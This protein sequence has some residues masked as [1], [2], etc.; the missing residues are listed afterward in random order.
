MTV[1]SNATLGGSCVVG[2]TAVLNGATI[3]PGDSPG[4]LTI[5]G[6]LTWWDNGNNFDWELLKLATAGVAG[7][8]LAFAQR[9]RFAQSDQPEPCPALQDQSLIG[10]AG[11]MVDHGHVCVEDP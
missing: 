10:R 11:G 6:D 1:Q 3:T 5:N 2:S 9:E 7:N 4:T 8:G